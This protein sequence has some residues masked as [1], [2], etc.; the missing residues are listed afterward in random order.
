MPELRP[1]LL[2]G[3]LLL[4][5]ASAQAWKAESGSAVPEGWK[6]AAPRE[7]IKPRFSYEPRGGRG[8]KGALVIE[9]D[10]REGLD[11]HWEKSFPVAG[12]EYYRFTA[13]RRL[14]GAEWPQH[15]GVVKIRWRDAQGKQ[16]LDDRPL[17]QGFLEGFTAW[18]PPEHPPDRATDPAGWTEVSATYQA[19]STATQAVVELHLQWAPKGRVA[20]S[21]VTFTQMAAPAPRKVRL[22]TVHHRPREGKTPEEKRRQFAPLIQEAARRKAD[23]VVLPETLTYYGTGLS[24]TQV[25]ESVPGPSTEYF[26]E[27]ARRN[28]LYIVAGL[29]ERDGCLIYNVAVLLSPEGRL[30]GKYRKVTLP[31]GEVAQGIMPGR[32]YPVFETRFGK[33]GMMI[34]YDGFFPEVARELTKRGAEVIAWPVWGCNPDLAR[35]RAVENQVYVVSSTYEDI[36]RHWMLTAVW[37]HAGRTIALAKEW[38]TVAVAEVD[39]AVPTRWRSLGDFRSKLPRHVPIIPAGTT[40]R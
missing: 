36:S 12:A 23:L 26:A 40:F 24:F 10:G 2:A 31:D 16:V 9:A 34:C 22:A 14:Q 28:G 25:A 3:L 32:D 8:G 20:W 21:D 35:A 37:D 1:T 17:V 29:V 6:E 30:A 38:G 15:S 13:W 18:A 7:E 27:L 5:A 39:L 19:P 4:S 11:G 33:L